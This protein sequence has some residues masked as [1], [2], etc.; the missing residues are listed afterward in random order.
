MVD[1][2]NR[3]R[4]AQPAPGGRD[5][6]FAVK[7][8]GH[9]ASSASMIGI[10][11]SL[12]FG[13]LNGDDKVAVKPHASPVFHAIK[14]LTGELDRSYLTT[15]RQL[16]GLQSYPSRTKDPDVADFS[17]GSVGLGRYLQ[18]WCVGTWMHILRRV[19]KHGSLRSSA[20]PNSTKAT[21]GRR[22]LIRH[23]RDLAT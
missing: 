23:C 8:G 2:A 15:L 14:Y 17:T 21:S 6:E 13:H 22:L 3:E 9:M 7:V 1:H 12:W 4:A 18:R 19:H 10:M 16:G 11:T 5:A 20:T